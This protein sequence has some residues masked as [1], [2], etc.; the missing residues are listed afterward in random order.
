MT[1]LIA[2][3]P[4]LPLLSFLIL[5]LFGGQLSRKI[6]GWIGAGSV[7]VSA[8]LTIFVG[9]S[10]I[11]SLPETKSYSVVIWQWLHAGNLTANIAFSLDRVS[12]SCLFH[13]FY[14]QRRRIHT[15]FRLHESICQL[16]ADTGFGG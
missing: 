8:L 15:V 13:W 11:N 5:V 1:N 7:G 14:G 12:H 9:I 3:I 6:A 4:A 10:F 16:D 2:L